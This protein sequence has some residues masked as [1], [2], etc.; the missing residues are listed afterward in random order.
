MRLRYFIFT[1]IISASNLF[2]QDTLVCPTTTS[3][4]TVQGNY[5]VPSD[6]NCELCGATSTSG[7]WTGSDC[8][9][10]IVTSVN[11]AAVTSLHLAYASVN[12]DDYALIEINNNGSMWLEAIN[13]GVDGDTIGPFNCGSTTFGDVYLTVHS[14]V[15]F[16]E[17]TLTNTGCSSG[18]VAVCVGDNTSFAGNDTLINLCDSIIDLDALISTADLGGTWQE[19]TSSGQFNAS[20]G[21][22]NSTG[23]YDQTFLFQYDVQSCGPKDSSLVTIKTFHDTICNPPVIDSFP[24]PPIINNPGPY[25]VFSPNNDGVNDFFYISHADS[26][27][28]N[29]VFIYNRWGNLIEQYSNYNNNDISWKGIGKNGT[30]YPPG[31]YFYVFTANEGEQKSGWVQIVK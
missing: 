3:I 12:L 22:F 20:G 5:S 9:G 7:A 6:P 29:T 21:E 17:V 18:W 14:D 15:P 25:N 8:S 23:L 10:S 30:P 1:I 28:I 13:M 11:G 2:G 19:I 26:F 4:G 24:A 27:A 31:T 16:T